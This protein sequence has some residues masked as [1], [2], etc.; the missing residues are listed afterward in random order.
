[1][2]YG[3]FLMSVVGMHCRLSAVQLPFI[4]M[5]QEDPEH[6]ATQDWAVGCTTCSGYA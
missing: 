5:L 3:Y 4:N 1:M 2:A 6:V